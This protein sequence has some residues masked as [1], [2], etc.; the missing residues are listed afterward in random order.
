M[1]T[2]NVGAALALL[3]GALLVSGQSC[4]TRVVEGK[5]RYS[6]TI[7]QTIPFAGK[8]KLTIENPAGS[9]EIRGWDQA[10]VELVA[11]KK[12]RSESE[13]REIEVEIEE[14]PNT[15]SIRS[16]HSKIVSKW[17]VDYRLK[18]PRGV[19]LSIDQ[20]AGEVTIEDHEGSI[21]VDLGAGDLNLRD[22]RAPRITLDV[23]AGDVDLLVLEADSIEINLGTGDL[24]LR[25]PP[26]ASFAVDTDVGVGD[27]TIAGFEAMRIREEGLIARSAEGTLGAGEGTLAI[28]VGV[29]DVDV[30]PGK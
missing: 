16:R 26:D 8:T 24:D 2:A 25:L 7:Q 4:A 22:V 6:E 29:G 3:L 17:L 11:T 27:L 28:R 14:G 12:A 20:G 9:I 5:L 1:R 10:A 18:V 23:G 19:E 15:L 13:L 30:R 21:A